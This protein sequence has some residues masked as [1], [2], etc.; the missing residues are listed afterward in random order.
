MPTP[1]DIAPY[2]A[3]RDVAHALEAIEDC[4][5]YAAGG[6]R[7]T[8]ERIAWHTARIRVQLGLHND[9]TRTTEG[10]TA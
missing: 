7:R 5:R 3:R 2:R 1:I 9:Q 4:A 10:G 8:T 6:S